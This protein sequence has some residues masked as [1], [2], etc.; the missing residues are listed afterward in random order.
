MNKNLINFITV[1]FKIYLKFIVNVIINC[2]YF[3]IVY[4]PGKFDRPRY[5]IR[6][7]NKEIEKCLYK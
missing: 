5:K 4:L 7:V 6:I 2:V 1:Y 3:Y